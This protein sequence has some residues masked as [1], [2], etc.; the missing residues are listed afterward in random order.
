M[1]FSTRDNRHFACQSRNPGRGVY[2][3]TWSQNAAPWYSSATHGRASTVIC[4]FG[5]RVRTASNAG[6]DITASPTQLVARTRI[7]EYE[8]KL[9]W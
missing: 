1:P 6:M 3:S 8:C 4:A 5:N 9:T 7:R 2:S